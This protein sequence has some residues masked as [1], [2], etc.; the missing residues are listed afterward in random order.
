MKTVLL[1][2]G[3]LVFLINTVGCGSSRLNFEAEKEIQSQSKPEDINPRVEAL[4]IR[5]SI[6]ELIGDFKSALDAYQ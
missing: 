5:G 4:V 1:L 6:A 2:F 3:Y